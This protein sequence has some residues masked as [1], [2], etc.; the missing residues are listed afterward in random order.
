[1]TA[2]PGGQP[3]FKNVS[4]FGIHATLYSDGTATGHVDCVDQM[5][6]F[7]VGNIFGEVTRWSMGP[8]GLSLFVT[9]DL[10]SIPGGHPVD[11]QF[12]VTI[13]A[14][15]GAGVGHWTL[16]RDPAHSFCVELLLS[17]HLVARWN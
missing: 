16:G 17:G 4:S 10:V 1:M 14:F 6:D 9:G 11:L 12:V 8:Y 3:G 13:Q 7:S 5:G 15:G 2:P